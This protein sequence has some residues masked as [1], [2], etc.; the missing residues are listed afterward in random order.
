MKINV[1]V[2]EPQCTC[3]LSAAIDLEV[4]IGIQGV[5]SV[6][7]TYENNM[8]NYSPIVLKEEGTFV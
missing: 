4:I 5:R 3:V 6:I 2:L 1:K 7:L 8:N